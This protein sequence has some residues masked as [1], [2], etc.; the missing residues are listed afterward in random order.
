MQFTYVICTLFEDM[1]QVM[2]FAK[3]LI[4]VKKKIIDTLLYS[5]KH[6]MRLKN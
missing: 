2:F 1:T 3:C 4:L 5:I 6:L